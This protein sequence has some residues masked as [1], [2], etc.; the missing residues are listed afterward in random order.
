[1]FQLGNSESLFVKMIKFLPSS[2]CLIKD[3]GENDLKCFLSAGA[4]RRERR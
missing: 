2:N 3:F 1:M 4:P